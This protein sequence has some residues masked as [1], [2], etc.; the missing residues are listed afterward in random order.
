MS[1]I[2]AV[3]GITLRIVRSAPNC[4]RRILNRH[5]KALAR[6][7]PRRSYRVFRLAHSPRDRV[8][9]IEPGKPQQNGGHERTHL[10]LKRETASPPR[11]SLAAQQRRFDAFRREFNEDRP[12]EALRFATPA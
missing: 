7:G 11:H 2:F 5:S 6:S 9:R 4:A 3:H 8:E 12:H 1:A 10:T